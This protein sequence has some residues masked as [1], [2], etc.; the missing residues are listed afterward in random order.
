MFKEF[1]S[2]AIYDNAFG[3]PVLLNCIDGKAFC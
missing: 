2:M 1:H 3:N